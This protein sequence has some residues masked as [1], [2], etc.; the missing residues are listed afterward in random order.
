MTAYHEVSRQPRATINLAK[1]MRLI[2]DRPSLTEPEV[3][4]TNGKRRKSAF[5]EMEEGYMFVEE[6]FRIKFQNG[7]T[8]DFYADCAED[9]QGWMTILAETIGGGQENRNWC[10][11]I[12]NKEKMDK[13]QSLAAQQ[14][15]IQQQQAQMQQFE[16]SY[17]PSTPGPLS[18]RN[19]IN[20]DRPS[21]PPKSNKRPVSGVPAGYP[22]GSIGSVHS[23]SSLGR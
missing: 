1:A 3:H 8:I 13:E 4:V 20:S 12:L 18:G 5:A 7:E 14:R 19:D 23:T 16:K 10:E 2:D 17:P 21:P 11:I 9:K 15:R 6:G 22:Q